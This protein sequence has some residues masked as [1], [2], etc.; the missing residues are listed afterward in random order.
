M[1]DIESTLEMALAYAAHGWNVF[2]TYSAEDG[3][4]NCWQGKACEHPA[5]HPRTMNGFLDATTDPEKI[6]EW[7]GMWPASNVAIRTGKESGIVVVDIDPGHGGM[8]TVESLSVKGKPLIRTAQVLTQNDGFHLY[9]AYP[10]GKAY[11]KSMNNALGPGIDL[12]AD[13]GY[14]IAPPSRGVNGPYV[15]Q[16]AVVELAAL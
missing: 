16:V 6:R 8:E 11:I 2:P 5:K 12:K 14:V 13:K 7:W 3:V 9:Y 15:W 1:L 10:P 4:C